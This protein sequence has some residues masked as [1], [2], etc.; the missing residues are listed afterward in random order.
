MME[1]ILWFHFMVL[2][3][4][5]YFMVPSWGIKSSFGMILVVVYL[6]GVQMHFSIA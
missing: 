6:M 5:N 1:I 4:G 3:D 2:Y